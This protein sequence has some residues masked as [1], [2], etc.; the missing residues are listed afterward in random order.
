MMSTTDYTVHDAT[1]HFNRNKQINKHNIHKKVFFF[2]FFF[3][4]SS[5]KTVTPSPSNEVVY[6]ILYG[7]LPPRSIEV[8]N[9]QVKCENAVKI[10]LDYRVPLTELQKLA[11][12]IF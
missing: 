5:Q 11:W 6:C 1:Q 4:C 9:V 8:K 2:F 3:K 10:L 12:T 7:K